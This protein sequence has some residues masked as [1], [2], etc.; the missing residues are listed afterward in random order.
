MEHVHSIKETEEQKISSYHREWTSMLT[1]KIYSTTL[2][3][4]PYVSVVT[5]TKFRDDTRT[6]KVCVRSVTNEGRK[7]KMESK[8]L[9]V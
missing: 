7:R 5:L 2:L 4:S 3:A 6:I 9:A 1:L 8:S